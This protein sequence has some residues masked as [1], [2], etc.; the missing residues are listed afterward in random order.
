MDE[1]QIPQA[2]EVQPKPVDPNADVASNKDIAALGYV[3]ILSI[4]VLIYRHSS[5]F[6]R[7][8]AKQ[9]VVLFVLS[10]IAG[11]LPGFIGRLVALFVLAFCVWGFVSAAQGKW[12]QLPLI[13]AMSCGDFKALRS[14]WKE[15]VRSIT[16]LWHRLRDRSGKTEPTKAESAPPPTNPPTTV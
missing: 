14:D 7:F 8:H 4:F 11:M 10:I 12:K 3:W 15:I 2:P 16:D 5:P 13:Y 1:Q 9:G 6:T